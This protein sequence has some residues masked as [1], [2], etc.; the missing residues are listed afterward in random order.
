[1]VFRLLESVDILIACFRSSIPSPP[2]PLFTLRRAPRDTLRK[3]RGRAVRYSFLVGIFHS[4]LHAGLS[5]RTEQANARFQLRLVPSLQI[6][7]GS[8]LAYIGTD[9][10]AALRDDHDFRSS[11]FRLGDKKEAAGGAVAVISLGYME[12]E[13]SL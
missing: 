13:C 3:T 8:S 9:S 6:L 12:I 4:L 5:R 11:R 1:V 7:S 2:V 10:G